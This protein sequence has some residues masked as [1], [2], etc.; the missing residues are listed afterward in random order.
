VV[1]G[2]TKLI[3]PDDRVMRIYALCAEP[4]SE[5]AKREVN[6]LAEELNADGISDDAIANFIDCIQR[7]EFVN[8]RLR[9]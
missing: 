2:T 5:Q 6:R 1:N 8:G 4:V 9:A 7:A 3:A